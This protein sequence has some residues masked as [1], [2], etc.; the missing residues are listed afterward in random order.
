[1]THAVE[2][3]GI[4][5]A[6]PGVLANDDIYFSAEK[7]EIHGLLGENGAGKTVLM[8]ILYGLYR[9]AEGKILVNGEEVV[10]ESPAKAMR[11]GI[12]MVHQHFMLVP[13]LTVAENI[14]LGRE[15][16]KNGVF[17]NEKKM[18]DQVREFCELYNLDVDL[19]APVYTLSV[20][21]QQRVE[22]LKALYRGA[23]ILILDEP[24]AVLTP[25]EVEELFRAV[26]ALKNE[27]KTVIFISHKLREVLAICDRITVLKRGRVVGTVNTNETNLGQLAKMMVGRE[28]VY[29]FDMERGEAET[30][31]L[32]VEGLEAIDDRGLPALRGVD[33]QVCASEIVGLAGVEGN[34]QKE[35]VEVLM[36]LRRVT[37]G[38]ILLGRSDITITP[39]NERIRAGI[40]HIPED[41][42]KWGLIKDFTVLENLILGS[43][44]DPRFTGRGGSIDFHEA[45]KYSMKLVRD[46]SIQTP[47]IDTPAGNLS[48]GT[49]Q[50]LIVAREFSRQPRLII[51]SQPTRG[52]DIGATEYVRG[53]LVEMRDR[54]SAVLL[55]SAD[56]D[57]IW[58][59]SDRIAVIYEGRIVTFKDPEETNEQ[60][61]GLL[62][63]SGKVE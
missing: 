48:G 6:F 26:R 63:A 23:D 35:L 31:V 16:K 34:G 1:M 33:L 59:L 29:T 62:M 11:L 52:L 14:I 61:L 15:P 4:T 40:S 39:P 3:R 8:S 36:G 37:G 28:V 25:H 7:G 58:A 41:R 5:K 22:I 38:R 20:G 46:Y 2:L 9:P 50:R 51:A 53:K 30:T 55:V 13:S 57:E 42:H 32:S 18:L 45:T 10:M 49:Q 43:H 56:L 44:R 19:E 47:N 12:G 24:T 21:V 27:G 54:G 60:E 17:L